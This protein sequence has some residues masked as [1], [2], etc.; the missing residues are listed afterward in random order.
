[1]IV[2][3]PGH[4]IRGFVGVLE[5]HQDAI[6]VGALRQPEFEPGHDFE[7]QALRTVNGNHYQIRGDSGSPRLAPNLWNLQ[8]FETAPMK[9]KFEVGPKLCREAAAKPQRQIASGRIFVKDQTVAQ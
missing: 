8:E 3:L 7:R 9:L 6:T 1:K 2:V 4:G 5:D